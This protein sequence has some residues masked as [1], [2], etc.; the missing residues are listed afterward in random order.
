MAQDTTPAI[1][2]YQGTGSQTTFPVPFDKGYYG[3]VKVAFVRR[4]LANY[5]YNVNPSDYTVNGRLYA[6][7]NG[8][9]YIYTHTAIPS[10]G[11]KIYNS[12]DVEQ[13]GVTVSAVAGQTITVNSVVYT[14][15]QQHDIENNMILTWL[16][17]TLNVG[18]YICIIRETERG[19]PYE[20]PNN[21]KHIERALDN[22]E[23]QV[24]EV[25]NKADNALL[26]DP[27]YTTDSNKLNPIDWMKTII[28]CTD[29]SVRGLRYA[30]GW[31]D[32]SFDDPNIAEGSKSWNHLLNADNIKNVRE[33]SRIE[34]GVTFYWVEYLASDGTWKLLGDSSWEGRLAAVEAKAETAY[35]TSIS[36]L[37]VAG[38]ADNKSDQAV[39]Y[40]QQAL[41]RVANIYSERHVFTIT[42]GQTTLQFTDDVDDKEIDLYWNGQLIT[43]TG[44]WT[45]SGDTITILFGME[46]GD[47][48]VV[49]LNVVRQVI[50][51]ADL[52]A[53][54]TNPNAHANLNFDCGTMS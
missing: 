43:K 28:R 23:R 34:D 35:Q 40:A 10:V 11:A 46:A 4:G 16:G 32:Y 20:M 14:R 31:L 39:I 7:A 54:N 12:S 44:N 17:A 45:V 9:T 25:A 37:G 48:V 24:Q 30:N 38:Q 21:Q 29:L 15:A 2:I 26:V 53:H 52:D 13:V 19:Q 27:S 18:D 33:R 42:S 1:V 47:T 50:N 51:V 36:A 5:T 22:I 41:D 6:W 3:D 8:A 49:F